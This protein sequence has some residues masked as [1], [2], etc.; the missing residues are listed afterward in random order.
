M[1]THDAPL[2]SSVAPRGALGSPLAAPFFFPHT[3][4]SLSQTYYF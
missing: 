2:S 4:A 3:L 1:S